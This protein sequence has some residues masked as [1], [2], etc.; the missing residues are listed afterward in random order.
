VAASQRGIV[1]LSAEGPDFAGSATDLAKAAV[2]DGLKRI[3][4]AADALVARVNARP[5]YTLAAL[6][7]AREAA[8]KRLVL[9]GGPAA[10]VRGHLEDGFRLP[11]ESPA[12]ADIANAVGAA[13][14]LPTASLEI[15]ADTGQGTLRAPALDLEERIGRSFTLEAARLRCKE[16]LAA[17]L[18]EEGV[19][20][21]PVE[22]LE[23]DLFATL[24]DSGYGARD[25]RV[26]CQAVPGLAGRLC[27]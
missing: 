20:D 4:Q 8:P 1:A 15:Y 22:V 13:L 6:K 25:I 24:S 12:H 21:A 3:R 27:P 19:P 18:A 11:A 5:V 2:E 26:A 23:A 14:T 17:H 9:V 7:A 16:L 10:C